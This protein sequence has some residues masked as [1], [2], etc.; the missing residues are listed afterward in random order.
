MPKPSRRD[1][2]KVAA[3]YSAGATLAGLQPAFARM[4]Q[5]ADKR[6]NIIVLLFDAMSARN[7]SVYGYSRP[8]TANLERFAERA[9]VYHSHYSGGNFTSPGTAS[10]LTGLYPWRHRAINNDSLVRRDLVENNLFQRIGSDYFRAGYGQNLWADLFLR[11]FQADLDLHLPPNAFVP[12]SNVPMPSE[13][14]PNDP[15]IA[16]YALDTFPFTTRQVEKKLPGSLLW[17]YLDLIRNAARYNPDVATKRYPN[18]MPFNGFFSYEHPFIFRGLE[19]LI[20]KLT[21]ADKPLFGYFHL[22]SPHSPYGPRREFMGKFQPMG[23]SNSKRHPLAVMNASKKEQADSRDL[24]DS[25]IADLDWEFGN[26]L[27]FLEQKGIL[28]TSYVI[29]TS[30]HGELFEHG[31]IGHGSSLLYDPVIHIPLLISA[32]GQTQRR[33]VYSSTSN[34][35]FLSTILNLAGKSYDQTDGQLLPGF[36]GTE[37]SQRSIFSMVAKNTAAT[38]PLRTGTVGLIKGEYKLIYYF[39]H[40]NFADQFEMYDLANDPEEKHDLFSSAPPEAGSMKEELLDALATANA[41]TE[42]RGRG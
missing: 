9:T 28:N 6:P 26:T 31:E 15:A 37:N 33:D 21:S 2:L 17:G 23:I 38:A 42:G 5:P 24:Y 35:D 12:N 39:G 29:V 30:D 14:L 32:P 25:F 7:L 11:Q 18:G 8:T 10:M 20:E 13:H 40:P 34:V 4:T 16:Y 27:D 1:F 19:N 41:E 3:A 36:G 22:F